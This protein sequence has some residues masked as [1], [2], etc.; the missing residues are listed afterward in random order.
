MSHTSNCVKSY[1]SEGGGQRVGT[2]DDK[3]KINELLAGVDGEDWTAAI[4]EWDHA[5]DLS[6]ARDDAEPAAAALGDAAAA[7]VPAPLPVESA[8]DGGPAQVPPLAEIGPM[9]A[10]VAQLAEIDPMMALVADGEIEL[11]LS[12]GAALGSLL[13]DVDEMET[14]DAPMDSPAALQA[15]ITA[16]PAEELLF[17]AEPPAGDAF[18]TAAQ[19]ALAAV[20]G[21]A[22]QPD[23]EEDGT[24]EDGFRETTAVALTLDGE[25]QDE[26]LD[27]A[28]AQDEQRSDAGLEPVSLDMLDEIVSEIA[29]IETLE[30]GQVL[31]PPMP[32]EPPPRFFA[33]L[34]PPPETV[35]PAA[36]AIRPALLALDLDDLERDA[37]PDP[38][39]AEG[40]AGGG[41]DEYWEW[42]AKTARAS[43][44][45]ATRSA[46]AADLDL[47][48]AQAA[49]ALADFDTAIAR[50][51][52][53]LEHRPNDLA[54]LQALWRLGRRGGATIEEESGLLEALAGLFRGATVAAFSQVRSELIARLVEPAE[55]APSP[56]EFEGS[57]GQLLAG[58][59]LA[60]MRGDW[61]RYARVA[62]QLAGTVA[63]APLASALYVE[64]A[65]R[66]EAK[67]DP[68]SAAEA[69][70]RAVEKNEGNKSAWE[71][72]VRCAR[73]TKQA[74]HFASALVQ[75]SGLWGSWQG[76]RLRKGALAAL[77]AGD[78]ALALD[79]CERLC[80]LQP[81][82]PLVWRL[83]ALVLAKLQRWE[84]GAEK[85]VESAR[86][87]EA[88]DASAAVAHCEAGDYFVRADQPERAIGALEQALQQAP[89]LVEAGLKARR[90]SWA[91]FDSDQRVGALVEQAA[92]SSGTAR[93]AALSAAA[94]IEQRRDR[95]AEAHALRLEAAKLPQAGRWTVPMLET[96]L[97]SAEEGG[98]LAEALALK[99]TGVPKETSYWTW[100]KRRQARA[101]EAAGQG[102][103]ALQCLRELPAGPFRGGA[104][105]RAELR[106]L[107]RPEHSA[108][109][110]LTTLQELAG[111]AATANEATELWLL[112]GGLALQSEARAE[113]ETSYERA[114]ALGGRGVVAGGW[115][116]LRQS[117]Q[118]SQWREVAL[119]YEALADINT[120]RRPGVAAAYA[121]RAAACR[122][123]KLGDDASARKAYSEIAKPEWAA[124]LGELAVRRMDR[125]GGDREAHKR[126]LKA[127]GSDPQLSVTERAGA[128]VQL[129][130]LVLAE[131]KPALAVEEYYRLALALAPD[132][133]AAQEGI[134]FVL[135]SQSSWKRLIERYQLRL[136]AAPGEQAATVLHEAIARCHRAMA[137][138]LSGDL[139]FDAIAEAW[140]QNIHALGV[141]QRRSIQERR[142]RELADLLG[143]ELRQTKGAKESY[144]LGCEL[145]RVLMRTGAVAAAAEAFATARTFEGTGRLALGL[146]L[147]CA[148]AL[149]SA[150]VYAAL[151][152]ASATVDEPTSR[153]IWCAQRAA[154]TEA[155]PDE[156]L[157]L[158]Q[159]AI[160]DAPENLRAICELRRLAR[161]NGDWAAALDALVADGRATRLARQRQRSF[162][163]AAEI[164]ERCVGD[165]P[166]AVKLYQEVVAAD[167]A[168]LQLAGR[169]EAL[170]E[171]TGDHRGLALLLTRRIDSELDTE[172]QM[173]LRRQL[174][175]L[176]ETQLDDDVLA[177]EHLRSLLVHDRSDR[178]VLER[179]VR[180]YERREL[181]VDAA[182]SLIRLARLERDR[183][184]LRDILFRLGSIYQ[185]QVG[186]EKRA[187]ISYGKV[188]ALEPE[189][190]EALFR[191][192]ELYFAAGDFANALNSTLKLLEIERGLDRQVDL[193]LRVAKIREDGLRD[194]HLAAQTLRRAMELAPADLKAI[195]ALCGF[196]A[197][198]GDQRSV[199]IHLD[200]SI[201][202]MRARLTDDPVE[203]FAYRALFRIFGW[204][205]HLDGRLCAAQ[206]LQ[207]LGAADKEEREFLERYQGGVGAPGAALGGAE[208]DNWLFMETIPGGFRQIFQL[209]TGPLSKLRR[210]DLRA[211]RLST[212]DR[213]SVGGHPVKRIGDALAKDFGVPAYE[214]YV[215][216]Q[217][218]R[219][220]VVENTDPPAVILGSALLDNATEAEVQFLMGRC[221]WVIAKSMMLPARF[222]EDVEILVAGVVRQYVSD[223]APEGIEPGLLADIT[224][225]VGR[226]MPRR[227]KQELMPFA[228][229]CS[230]DAVPLGEIG[231]AV[232]HSA[233]RAGLLACRSIG[234]AVTSLRKAAE[235][236]ASPA[237]GEM[238]VL[239]NPEAEELLR[240][241]VSDGYFELR[242]ATN[243]AI[244]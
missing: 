142:W 200:R 188:I 21:A 103:A 97:A 167:S 156:A 74:K 125:Q 169:L 194:H 183:A 116:L 207:A 149:G 241:A 115:A 75:S 106:L 175:D 229:E 80:E 22:E 107:A 71:G 168:N 232:I 98:S 128:L 219:C 9:S 68:N 37:L 36:P 138:D 17:V 146:W 196:Y 240:F 223:F 66:Y 87:A 99:A 217:A 78:E 46:E 221:L 182:D 191:L 73:S 199:M 2:E 212:Q 14:A 62:E 151:T 148:E 54:A 1:R 67:G 205:K 84:L 186:D 243:V 132:D 144:A 109:E 19:R 237:G 165:Q 10:Q 43:A 202:T 70:R 114:A 176:A 48:A 121:L 65:R 89:D 171:A 164:A 81:E 105:R 83:H 170:L 161:V 195:G 185:R 45:R 189:H 204:R 6:P 49:E 198:Q 63:D 238:S 35:L 58:L 150:S 27:D 69:Y 211:H 166:R 30:A 226:V 216:R 32:V 25:D 56:S 178:E 40:E 127:L 92:Q 174:A 90:L 143:R 111:A 57:D 233:N 203:L 60:A 206:V 93:A 82:D 201:A 94:A 122:E 96:G 180:V 117:A 7:T 135:R 197:R 124:E 53:V 141:L 51:R 23:D 12:A 208:S 244:R 193:L 34:V 112:R 157:T 129:A 13:G 152:E 130:E 222:P 234:A 184:R 59:E 235:D 76:K 163:A 11:D 4:D 29:P 213:V 133:A 139:S 236:P 18:D 110:A 224:K 95:V 85:M 231:P 145:G 8:D 218:P 230:G 134:E 179:L 187:I 102:D 220:I 100:L 79:C 181:W 131:G 41:D 173:R 140:P 123:F 228:L 210:G 55:G 239:D 104:G 159:Q 160:D 101:L 209:M 20:S 33:R 28:L 44:L 214:L 88:G 177:T 172:A 86:R 5:L 242:R 119:R 215:S 61:S 72:R 3:K 77:A 225:Q 64:A 31:P 15:A 108:T 162:A 47:A 24:P 16:E 137:D 227:L 136:S 126:E 155:D 113:V 52:E 147:Q 153:S 120:A 118:R 192:S 158:L 190:K 39:E 91:G 50:Y 154:L 42:V 26:D 38:A